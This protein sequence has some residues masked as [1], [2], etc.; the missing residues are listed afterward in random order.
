MSEE[1]DYIIRK[2]NLDTSSRMPIRFPLK[3]SEFARLLAELGYDKGAEIGVWKGIY[4][5]KMCRANPDLTLHAIDPWTNYS[6]YTEVRD[7]NRIHEAYLEAVERLAQYKCRIIKMFSMEAVKSFE[8]DSLDFVYIDGN[9]DFRHV[10][11]DIDEWGKIVR[12]GGIIAGHDFKRHKDQKRRF[13]CHVKDV[14]SAYTYAH[15]IKPWFVIIG[16]NNPSWFW[17]KE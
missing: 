8:Y 4:A 6:E 9:H 3:R 11:D 13:N 10:T 7:Q 14:V 5:E 16:E 12:S 17:V 1:L 2:F 15:Q